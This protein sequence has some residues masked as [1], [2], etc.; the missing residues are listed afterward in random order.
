MKQLSPISLQVHLFNH[1]NLI[2]YSL[3]QSI[4]Y[5]LPLVYVKNLVKAFL[6]CKQ[7]C[8]LHGPAYLDHAVYVYRVA[9]KWAPIKI[10]LTLPNI[11]GFSQLF[12]CENHEKFVI[13]LSLKIPPHQFSRQMSNVSALLLDDALKPAMPL[14]NGTIKETQRHTLD[15]SQSSVATHLRCG[16]IVLLQFFS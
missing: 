9:Q 10:A 14:T 7:K 12:H 8:A 15:I 4:C 5:K 16:G 11:N 3:L 6:R 2:M 13:K 1:F